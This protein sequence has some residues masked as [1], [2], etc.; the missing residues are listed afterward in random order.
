M[1]R[2]TRPI[3]Y[4][5]YST[6]II[7][8]LFLLSVRLVKLILAYWY[9]VM[10]GAIRCERRTEIFPMRLANTHRGTTE[11]CFRYVWF[12]TIFFDRSHRTRPIDNCT[13]N[14][15]I[16]IV[17]AVTAVRHRNLKFYFSTTT[18]GGNHMKVFCSI[19]DL[20]P[21]KKCQQ[22]NLFMIYLDAV[23]AISRVCW[24]ST[25]FSLRTHSKKANN[26]W[27]L[28]FMDFFFVFQFST[29]GKH[30]SE[31]HNK[32]MI[33]M[34][35]D[36]VDTHTRHIPF[37]DFVF[38]VWWRPGE[39]LQRQTST[40]C[41]NLFILKINFEFGTS[42]GQSNCTRSSYS[43]YGHTRVQGIV[44]HFLTA[45]AKST[46]YV[47]AGSR[48]ERRRRKKKMNVDKYTHVK[49][50]VL[51]EALP[52][53]RCRCWNLICILC[54]SKFSA[55]QQAKCKHVFR[56]LVHMLT[57]QRAHTHTYTRTHLSKMEYRHCIRSSCRLP[58]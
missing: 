15:S 11:R 4:E 53:V 13:L 1:R 29:Y 2:R 51:P 10:R 50:L 55:Q 28:G 30:S 41:I 38:F 9:I 52:N 24:H 25:D 44:V 43:T 16:A 58:E 26:R 21:K 49:L 27:I 8:L 48:E 47:S 33:S 39:K 42:S 34:M 45:S 56:L 20:R 23:D 5:N 17:I 3:K 6:R 46:L 31:N 40:K 18:A 57:R 35:N 7:L 12:S 54:N 14:K 32:F 19:F 22:F 37:S 36:F